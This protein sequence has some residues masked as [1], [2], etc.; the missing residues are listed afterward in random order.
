M[1]LPEKNKNEIIRSVLTLKLLTFSESGAILA[2]AT[3]SI[4]EEAG[5][6]RTWDY[7][8]CWIRDAS[9]TVDALKKIGRDAEAKHLMEFIFKNTVGKRKDIQIMY[10]IDGKRTLTEKYLNHLSGYRNSTPVRIGNAAYNQKQNDIYGS[11]IDVIYLYYV[12]YEYDK[13]LPKKYWI[14]LKYLVSEIKNNWKKKDKGIWEFRGF[15]KHFT[16]SKLMCYIGMDRAV[17]I[18]QHFKQ[19]KLAQDWI[20]L[21]EEIK[22]DILK[23]AWSEKKRA[24]TMFY[25]SEDLDA[26]VLLMCYH[27]FLEPDDPRLISTVNQIN[28]ELRSGTSVNRYKIKDDFGQSTSTFTICA[29][30]LVDALN[31]IGKRE[32]A[33]SLYEKLLKYSN[34]LGLFSEDLEEKT[35]NLIGNFPQAYTHIA[36][37]NTSIV[38][39]EWSTKRIKFENNKKKLH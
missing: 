34:H 9:F 4:P 5:S 35:K 15:Q 21:A 26:A 1:N 18:A 27:N 37:I 11:I 22:N 24:F 7:R 33:Q 19:D 25:G 31:Y 10:G 16:Y 14:F 38:L 12:F 32:E 8:F 29:F 13:R 2:A 30:W 20:Y 28:E 17:K 23:N 36:I 6:N 39:S 3:T